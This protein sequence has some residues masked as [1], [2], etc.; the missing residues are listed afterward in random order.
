M[1]YDHFYYTVPEVLTGNR[2]VSL[3]GEG[4]KEVGHK[5]KK[6]RLSDVFYVF[7]PR[8]VISL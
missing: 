6:E 7:A 8:I 5:D 1:E 4:V 3:N 2:H